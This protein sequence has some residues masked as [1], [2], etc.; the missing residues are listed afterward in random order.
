[1]SAQ[2]LAKRRTLAMRRMGLAAIGI[3][4]LVL[5]ATTF[6]ADLRIA[7]P[8]AVATA[9]AGHHATPAHPADPSAINAQTSRAFVD[10]L[11]KELMDWT[12]PPCLSATNDASLRGR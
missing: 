10:E 1:M 12:P 6:G 3:S 11:Y 4:F 8:S 7:D 5:S 2:I 9:P